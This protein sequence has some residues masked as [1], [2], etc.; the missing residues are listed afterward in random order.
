MRTGGRIVSGHYPA[1]YRRDHFFSEGYER[2]AETELHFPV[3]AA[4]LCGK[5]FGQVL[6]LSRRHERHRSTPGAPGD[7]VVSVAQ[8]G[9]RD[10]GPR[11]GVLDLGQ[12]VQRLASGLS[13]L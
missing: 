5:F 6:F 7:R 11:A 13:A 1:E 2:A 8:Q 12:S 3:T 10:R 4:E 9:G